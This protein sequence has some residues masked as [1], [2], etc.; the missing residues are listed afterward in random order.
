MKRSHLSLLNHCIGCLWFAQRTT[1]CWDSPKGYLSHPQIRRRRAMT[2]I[3][4]TMSL[5]ILG[6]AMVAVV[7]LL[8]TTARQRRVASERRVAL[9]EV[10][11][12]AERIALLH[13]NQTAADKLSDWQPSADLAAVLPAA[14]FSVEVTEQS[15]KP[16]TRQIRLQVTWSD[17]AGQPVDPVAVT[18]WKFAKED[19]P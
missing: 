1:A 12:E 9:A 7:Q 14:R 5:M 15:E 11:N 18:V 16:R 10:A 3:E 8:A 13:W 6:V 17:S 2:L 4:L 19:R